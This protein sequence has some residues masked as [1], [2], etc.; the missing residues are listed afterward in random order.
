MKQISHTT[1]LSALAVFAAVPAFAQQGQTAGRAGQ[2]TGACGQTA[3]LSYTLGQAIDNSP[4]APLALNIVRGEPAY[5]EFALEA[6]T[7]FVARTTSSNSEHDP[8]LTIY[9]TRGNVVV[10]DDDSAGGY[11]S[12]VDANLDAGNYCA[13]V[14]P[15]SSSSGEALITT[16]TIA[17]GEAAEELAQT[18][19]VTDGPSGTVTDYSELCTNP[20]LT[21]SFD[22]R[23]GP[24]I[25]SFELGTTVSGGARQ[26]WKFDVAERVAIQITTTSDDFDTLL[27]LVDANGNLITENDDGADGTNSQIVALLEPGSYCASLK[28]F[29]G[30]GGAAT[31][32]V[33]DELENPP[34]GPI[35]TACSEPAITQDYERIIS[36]GIGTIQTPIR[37]TPH[38][39]SDWRVEISESMQLQIDAKSNVF[40]TYLTILDENGN[41]V[42]ENDDGLINTDSRIVEALA[43]GKY[44]IAVAGYQGEYGEA[45]LVISDNPEADPAE[46]TTVPGCTDPSLTT[47][48]SAA[49]TPETGNVSQTVSI[50]PGK[51][52][53]W[54]VEVAE[55][56]MLRLDASSADFDTTLRISDMSQNLIAENDDII[57]GTGTNSRI[58]TTLNPGSYCITLEGFAGSGGSA[59]LAVLTMNEETR[60]QLAIERGETTPDLSL[61]EDLGTL[62]TS[63]QSSAMDPKQTQWVSFTLNEADTVN[64]N[65]VSASGDFTLRLFEENGTL[66]QEAPG[67]EGLTPSTLTA[68]LTPGKYILGM[69]MNDGVEARLR[70]I[71]ITRE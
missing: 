10:S 32:S 43:P 24:G 7:R 34:A 55:D 11:D 22:R 62:D 66:I 17:T 14:R 60:S 49:L 12:M 44:C 47:E 16:L 35:E 26:D 31:V 61:I 5:L 19:T 57:S 36:P 2:A 27:S 52:Q 64:V 33:T 67:Q 25:G 38:S 71:V 59:E 63:L 29:D 70:N 65:A 46:M 23:I 15:L 30:G 53:D 18:A 45:E 42:A 4:V 41:L 48:L 37:V 6:D 28:G 54:T 39:R 8:F 3:A 69:A 56:V 20:A 68:E 50:E 58:E 51:R 1:L 21:N 13:Q 40:D 9:N